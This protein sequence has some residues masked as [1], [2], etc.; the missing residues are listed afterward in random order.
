MS[1]LQFNKNIVRIITF[2]VNII[3]TQIF[4]VNRTN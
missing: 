4:N 1:T 3:R 2:N